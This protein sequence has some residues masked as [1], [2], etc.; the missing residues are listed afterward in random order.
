MGSFTADFSF[1][2]GG[3]GVK[4]TEGVDHME[5][6]HG[7]EGCGRG[8]GRRRGREC[9]LPDGHEKCT[10]STKFSGVL[11]R[12]DNAVASLKDV[13]GLRTFVEKEEGG[14]AEG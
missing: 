4:T 14:Y 9:V 2:R 12:G 7:E 1:E 6:A 8:T 11:S 13:S 3:E 10:A 5:L